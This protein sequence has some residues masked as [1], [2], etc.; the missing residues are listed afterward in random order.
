MGLKSL[1]GP[2]IREIVNI[3]LLEK[4]MIQYRN[5]CTRVGTPVYDA[6]HDRC[7]KGV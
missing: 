3:T 6:H 4:G 2:L 1:S 5:V 7:R